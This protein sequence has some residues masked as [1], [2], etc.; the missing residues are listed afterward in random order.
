MPTIEELTR[1]IEALEAALAVQPKPEKRTNGSSL[2]GLVFERLRD[3]SVVF[4]RGTRVRIKEL[5]DELGLPGDRL[6]ARA[7]GSALRAIGLRQAKSNGVSWFV[8]P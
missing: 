7:V 1:R 4:P 5:A 8:M 3:R 6:H 2:S